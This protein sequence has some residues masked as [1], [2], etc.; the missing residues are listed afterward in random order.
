ML[1]ERKKLLKKKTCSDDDLFRLENIEKEIS[2]EILD[3]EFKKLEKALG[4]LETDSGATDCTS[5][6]KELRKAYPKNSM[7]LPT[8]VMNEMGKG[9][10]QVLE[11]TS[12]Y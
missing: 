8:G 7:T 12:L 3:I 4:N 2:D 1:N 9:A 5:I 11:I 6:W 10:I